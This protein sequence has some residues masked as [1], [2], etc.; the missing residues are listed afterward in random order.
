MLFEPDN[1]HEIY[2]T[3]DDSDII[4][5]IGGKSPRNTKKYREW[6]AETLETTENA[7]KMLV[8]T[9]EW[10]TCGRDDRA[11]EGVRPVRQTFCWRQVSG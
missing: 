5:E 7:D 9:E 1:A 3:L 10:K 11:P 2:Y 6:K 4:K 8:S